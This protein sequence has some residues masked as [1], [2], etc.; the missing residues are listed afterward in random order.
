MKGLNFLSGPSNML[1]PCVKNSPKSGRAVIRLFNFE[2]DVLNYIVYNS[3]SDERPLCKW[4]HKDA[5]FL[6][7]EKI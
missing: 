5:K 6:P 1:W 3:Y 7:I 4:I 2:R